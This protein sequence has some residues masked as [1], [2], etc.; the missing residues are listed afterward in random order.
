MKGNVFFIVFLI[1]LLLLL[2]KFFWSDGTSEPV[3]GEVKIDLKIR[4]T[5]FVATGDTIGGG[6]L[7]GS[8]DDILVLIKTEVRP[9]L[10]EFKWFVTYKPI[11]L[12]LSFE[13]NKDIRKGLKISTMPPGLEV[14]VDLDEYEPVKLPKSKRISLGLLYFKES[15]ALT[16]GIQWKNNELG[17]IKSETHWGAYVRTSMGILN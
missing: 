8:F 4:D 9:A 7:V 14:D 12:K 1:V 16:A 6:V 11:S 15:P 2:W 3:P 17:V 10:N 5:V 13:D